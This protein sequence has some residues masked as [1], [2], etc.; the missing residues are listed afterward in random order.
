MSESLGLTLGSIEI[1]VLISSILFGVTT[2][3][4]YLYYQ[5]KFKDLWWTRGLVWLI[6]LTELLHTVFFWIYLYRVT[7]TYY[8]DPTHLV[9]S[10]WTL[11][12]SSF[13][14]GL[15]G[16]SVQSLPLLLIS[17][18]VS[19][20]QFSGALATTIIGQRTTLPFF[21]AHYGWIVTMTLSLCVFVDIINT[22]GLCYFL[23]TRKSGLRSTNEIVEKLIIWTVETGLVTTVAALLM[24][25]TSRALPDTSVWICISVF[26]AKLYSNSLLASSVPHLSMPERSAYIDMQT[27]WPDVPAPESALRVFRRA[28][29]HYG[30]AICFRAGKLLPC[31]Y[32]LWPAH[33]TLKPDAS[34]KPETR[35]HVQL[36]PGAQTA[37]GESSDP[38]HTD[39]NIAL[40]ERTGKGR[41]DLESQVTFDAI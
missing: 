30:A 14:D 36:K 21:A 11:N 35:V 13:F 27:E 6:W 18:A 33:P 20:V 23:W 37:S 34:S 2:V 24:L 7:V 1:G 26:Y 12:V 25:I 17:W 40:E 29:E 8:G 19:L 3:Q 39:D 28:H 5:G 41:D 4:L 16:G 9:E 10:H 32:L 15:I 31:R 22:V 38:P